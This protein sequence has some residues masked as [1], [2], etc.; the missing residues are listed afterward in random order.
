[1]EVF[2]Y[3]RVSGGG[4][5]LER[6]R[7]RGTVSGQDMTKDER[8]TGDRVSPVTGTGEENA[9]NVGAEIEFEE[10]F[11]DYR[12]F[13]GNMFEDEVSLAA[14]AA[15]S[16]VK[17]AE[18][19]IEVRPEEKTVQSPA[20]EAGKVPVDQAEEK[21]ESEL[22][23]L[24]SGQISQMMEEAEREATL[25][26]RKKRK[27][28]S[29]LLKKLLRASKKPKKISADDLEEDEEDWDDE[30]WGDDS[31]VEEPAASEHEDMAIYIP[32][33]FVPK[34][35][36]KQWKRAGI[37]FVLLLLCGCLVGIVYRFMYREFEGYHVLATRK[38]EDTLSAGY[39]KVGENILRYGVDGATLTKISG[40][41]IWD[42]DYTMKA[43]EAE[44]L[45]TGILI[46]DK[47]G[48][49]VV[50]CGEK[51]KKNAFDTSY[52]VIR[53]KSTA[54]GSVAALMENGE[55]T[56]IEY[57]K[58]DG[59]TIATIKASMD[60]PGYPLDFAISPNGQTI[61][62]A[63]L[64]YESDG[65]KSLVA[66]YNFGSAGS[67]ERDNCIGSYEYQGV[68]I[69]QIDYLNDTTC[70][71][72]GD[73]CWKLFAGTSRMKELKS[74]EIKAEVRCV[75]SDDSYFGIV[76]G[77]SQGA[78]YHINLYRS[79][80]EVKCDEDLDFDFQ[81]AE[82]VGDEISFYNGAS[83]HMMTTSGKKRFDGSYMGSVQ[84]IFSMGDQKYIVVG[85]NSLEELE[86]K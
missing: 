15:L 44:V 48:T 7:S 5:F 75:L 34:L 46:Y 39:C 59:R 28:K 68:I 85:E 66:F 24:A 79:T 16:A 53:A 52:P 35:S 42:A 54:N 12:G 78:G 60:N 71:A 8:K 11:S 26:D 61:A 18:E 43:P 21:N 37:L 76:T 81:N 33:V 63:Y 65:Q 70:V 73:N 10:A 27:R 30:E 13:S 80:G 23:V 3:E 45:G 36:A 69:P 14:E 83:F 25:D 1:M 72:F 67:N 51:G 86:L 31:W 19:K 32:K 82:I 49:S 6:P 22:S 50:V 20:P 38:Q 29:G 74:G 57:Y 17:R 58:P 2:I 84:D 77:N 41:V 55:N 9:E 62:V 40:E 47:N 64:S 4:S 56:Y